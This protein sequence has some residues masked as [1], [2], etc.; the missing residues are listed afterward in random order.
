MDGKGRD[1]D[2]KLDSEKS[3][4]MNFQQTKNDSQS[5]KIQGVQ[6]SSVAL[7]MSVPAGWHGGLAPMGYDVVFVFVFLHSTL[8]FQI[9]SF[10]EIIRL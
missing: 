5:D 9:V 3:G 10:L 2:L 1:L 4:L 8:A 7:P 6:S